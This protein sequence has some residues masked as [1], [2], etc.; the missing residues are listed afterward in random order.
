LP[1]PIETLK[2]TKL[3]FWLSELYQRHIDLFSKSD[4]PAVELGTGE[5]LLK[6]SYPDLV[7]SDIV[8]SPEIDLVVDA[9]E[10]PFENDSIGNLTM[11]NVLYCLQQPLRFFVEAARVLKPEG[12]L[13][14][15]E[16][17]ISRFSYPIYKHVHSQ[18]CDLFDNVL[19]LPGGDSPIKSNQAMPTQLMKYYLEDILKQAPGLNLLSVSFHSSWS[20]FLTGGRYAKLPI[21]MK[22][23]KV[24]VAIDNRLCRLWG[25]QLASFMT[26]V[27]EKSK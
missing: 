15:T 4:G 24:L 6:N 18:Y 9:H 23:Y 22:A 8:E 13:I 7:T 17:Y 10:M 5:S 25:R 27:F 21:P 12:R 11:F 3:D 1:I 26:V 16:P 20:Y 2:N 19:R 14:F